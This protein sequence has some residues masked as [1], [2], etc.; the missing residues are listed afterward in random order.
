MTTF[1]RLC[2]VLL[3]FL[4]ATLGW[5][6]KPSPTP[7][8]DVAYDPILVPGWV[9]YVQEGGLFMRPTAG[10]PLTV[11]A[12]GQAGTV[13]SPSLTAAGDTVFATWIEKGPGGNQLF[14]ASVRNANG[15]DLQTK[16]LASGIK[17]TLVRTLASEHGELYL[18]EAVL[19]QDP[20]LHL[21]VSRDGAQTFQRTPLDTV[22]LDVIDHVSPLLLGEQLHVVFLGNKGEQRFIG[23]LAY[24]LGDMKAATPVQIKETEGMFFLK[25]FAASGRPGAIYKIMDDGKFAL[26]VAVGDQ[27]RWRSVPIKAA[28]GL[29]VAGTD[30]YAW[31]DGRVLIVFSGEQ[32]GLFKQ[33][34]Y[35]ALS[36]HGGA[37]WKVE[38]IDGKQHGNTRSWL[39]RLAVSGERVGVVW[40][41]SRQIRAGTRIKL[42]L[43]RG[44]TWLESAVLISDPKH[45]VL[46][47][48]I[49]PGNEEV[50]VAWHQYRTDERKAADIVAEQLAW[51]D[52]IER[53]KQ[54]EATIG[55]EQKKA[56]LLASLKRYWDGMV[57]GD[58][59]ISYDLHD[60]FY[61][62]RM[63]YEAY[64]L[65]RG[66][67]V[68]HRYKIENTKIAGS[69]ASVKLTVN[70]EI[71]R[72]QILGREQSV[73]PRDFP[74]EDTW[75]FI[76][77]GWYRKYVDAMS[78][79]SA[80][81]Y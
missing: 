25:A 30:E 59:R 66:R 54:P 74:I 18:F 61:R 35:A 49:S 72:L 50:Y 48:R 43:D 56:S 53:A 65:Q 3:F 12:P 73:P 46:R 36:E 32:K 75:L 16:E 38:R 11:R 21:T 44:E 2:W 23:A 26:H 24:T 31:P 80:I 79:G 45:Y 70:Y 28:E 41:D 77:G 62:A 55:I 51:E 52:L 5:G 63:S 68:Y 78:G 7:S 58:L 81:K 1:S 71:P 15:A 14:L 37:D 10:K 19:G 57:A 69:E 42:S 8:V 60:P 17:S 22:G 64:A 76:D 27:G 6:A 29:D 9:A 13:L 20:A 4:Y 34:I 67:I 33:Q 39:P 40:E 47:P